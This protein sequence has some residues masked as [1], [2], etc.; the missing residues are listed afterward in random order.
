M[1]APSETF[2]YS[3]EV[4]FTGGILHAAGDDLTG[5][6]SETI[7]DSNDG[8]GDNDTIFGDVFHDQLSGKLG[9]IPTQSGTYQGLASAGASS[10]ILVQGNDN[11]KLYYLTN[12]A[13]PGAG[14]DLTFQLQPD[15]ICF[16]HGT[17]VRTPD[18]E[19]PVEALKC[20]DLVT[21]TDGRAI[22]V[23]WIGRQT[24]S[25]TFADPL[26][27]NPIRIRANA[28]GESVP[29]RDLLVSPDHAILL[30]DVLVQAGALVNGTSIVRESNVPKVFTYFH[31][32]VDDH[33][34]ILAEGV[35]AET[36]IDNVDRLAFDNWDEHVALYPEGKAVVEMPHPRAKAYRQVPH[37]MREKLAARGVALYGVDVSSAA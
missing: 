15:V 3:Y 9:G 2:L 5:I 17:L 29:A 21:T 4:T 26:R 6:F 13:L 10:G 36:F 30:D 22:P 35:P 32:E 8:P 37:A 11:G 12:V 24:V 14:A 25:T 28:L 7:T 33:S 34:L 27:V 20:G 31:I 16:M 23:R 18:G 1:A 19:T